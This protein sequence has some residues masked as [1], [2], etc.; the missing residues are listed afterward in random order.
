MRNVLLALLLSA[1]FVGAQ[2]AANRLGAELI[3]KDRTIFI[4]NNEGFIEAISAAD[5]KTVWRSAKRARLLDLIEANPAGLVSCQPT[6]RICVAFFGSGGKLL[7]QSQSLPFP[8]F[9]P[10]PAQMED[11]LVWKGSSYELGNQ[12]NLLSITPTGS[13]PHLALNWDARWQYDGGPAPPS[14]MVTRKSS[15]GTFRVDPKTGVVT[16]TGALAD[17]GKKAAAVSQKAPVDAPRQY[18]S[19]LLACEIQPGEVKQQNMWKTSH[20]SWIACTVKQTRLKWKRE[21]AP[22]IEFRNI[23][24]P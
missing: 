20:S 9:A 21:L 6:P 18:E 10:P 14:E 24:R 1:V 8:D 12:D 3:L 17:T 23:P 19:A 15:A 2:T 7:K 4:T 22:R 11:L 5:G 13:S 16:T